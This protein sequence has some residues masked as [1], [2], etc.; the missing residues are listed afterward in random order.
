MTG[1]S[2]T[3]ADTTA[4]IPA[5]VTEELPAGWLSLVCV[6]CRKEGRF[7]G[8]SRALAALQAQA[9]GWVYRMRGGELC[10]KCA[11]KNKAAAMI[12]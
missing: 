8:V 11:G 7:P 5:A 4:N 1:A 6:K 10:P 3:A 9:K 12:S 2:E